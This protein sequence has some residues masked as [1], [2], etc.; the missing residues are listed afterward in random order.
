MGYKMPVVKTGN[1]IAGKALVEINQTKGLV[2]VT[3]EGKEKP[4][5][6]KII[7]A[8]EYVQGGEYYVK[9]NS[10]GDKIFSMSPQSGQYRVKVQ[11][12]VAKENEE[13]TWYTKKTNFGESSF[14]RVVLE[15]TKGKL[16]GMTGTWEIPYMFT[17]MEMEIKGRTEKVAAIKGDPSRSKWAKR[18]YEFCEVSGIED[19][20]PMAYKANLVPALA[21]RVAHANREF[22]VK[23][24]D[25]FIDSAWSLMEEDE[26][27]KP[28][29]NAPDGGDSWDAEPDTDRGFSDF[30]PT[31]EPDT[32][33]EELPWND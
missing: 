13:P 4:Y 33:D 29:N 16:K 14:F 32:D 3:F 15:I 20:G 12:F 28:D 21:K 23:Y 27:T 1:A 18:L 19:A 11:K 6:I 7:D 25:G 31:I 5:Y 17:E 22:Y 24:M 8:P 9:L 2:R 26:P 30:T 10:N